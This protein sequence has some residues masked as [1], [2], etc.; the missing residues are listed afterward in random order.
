MDLTDDKD[1]FFKTQN[2][3]EKAFQVLFR[4]YYPA[5]CHFACQFLNDIDFAEEVVQ[6]V[7][8]RIW[9]KRM[10][11]NVETS[12]KHYLFRS[13]RNHCFNQ[14]QHEKIKKQYANKVL[15][16]MYQEIDTE[17][18]FID[19]DIVQRIEKAIESLPPRRKEIFKL[20]REQGMK[21]KEIAECMGIS[22]KT[23]EVQMGL[24]LKY[25]RVELK[26]FCTPIS[27][28]IFILKKTNRTI[29]G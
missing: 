26:D 9:E 7:F 6:E 5:L 28:F 23:V 14:L 4:K 8:V 10:V 16:S 24:A 13:V 17:Q 25:L 11:L 12:V 1:L 21:Y 15:R 22:V 20:S 29:K 2:G 27:T 19:T 3:D 18:Y